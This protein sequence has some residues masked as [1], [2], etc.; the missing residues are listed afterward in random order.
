MLERRLD[1]DVAAINGT[2]THGEP[3]KRSKLSATTTVL[4]PY[5]KEENNYKLTSFV[6]VT[7]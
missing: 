4:A 3:L 1:R 2:T 7:F 5:A 6:F